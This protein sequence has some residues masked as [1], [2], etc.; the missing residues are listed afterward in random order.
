M[1]NNSD[2]AFTRG[3][4]THNG[5]NV[6]ISNLQVIN[7]EHDHKA[8]GRFPAL[9]VKTFEALS[10]AYARC[11]A[12]TTDLVASATRRA[13]VMESWARETEEQLAELE[14]FRKKQGN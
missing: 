7:P 13:E 3:N 5:H 1:D 9:Q 2:D 11:E 14:A 10:S 4:T 12:A 6:R 8:V